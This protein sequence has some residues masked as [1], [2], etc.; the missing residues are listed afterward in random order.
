[1]QQ[2]AQHG[3]EVRAAPPKKSNRGTGVDA[4][5]SDGSV[6]GQVEAE[7]G[8]A[9]T[10]GG[11]TAA[12]EARRSTLIPPQSAGKPQGDPAHAAQRTFTAQKGDQQAF[13]RETPPRARSCKSVAGQ[14]LT[15]LLAHTQPTPVQRSRRYLPP[16]RVCSTPHA[17]KKESRQQA[18]SSGMRRRHRPPSADRP[19]RNAPG[20]PPPQR[21][22]RMHRR[23]LQRPR[24][25]TKCQEG[26]AQQHAVIQQRVCSAHADQ[27]KRQCK[28]G[29]QR[30]RW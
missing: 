19:V 24:P 30:Y 29:R 5:C 23:R 27:N 17:N 8:R 26:A 10:L 6:A 16:N 18:D 25:A 4:A 20:V 3:S 15:R 7:Q 11:C 22:A 12:G 9:S 21:N 14:R 13:N 28:A 1:M 2:Y